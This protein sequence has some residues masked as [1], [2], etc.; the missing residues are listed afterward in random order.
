MTES[1]VESKPI[2]QSILEICN[3]VE[4]IDYISLQEQIHCIQQ[5][6]QLIDDE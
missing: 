5:I 4:N 1:K 3:S 2:D 6:R